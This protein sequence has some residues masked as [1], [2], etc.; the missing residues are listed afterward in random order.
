MVSFLV[1]RMGQIMAARAAELENLRQK[2]EGLTL[3]ADRLNQLNMEQLRLARIE[4]QSK[5]NQIMTDLAKFKDEQIHTFE[6]QLHQQVD[7]VQA[8]LTQHKQEVL[9]SP[10]EIVNRLVDD[11]YHNLTGK[12]LETVQ[13]DQM[14]NL[15]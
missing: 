10:R 9:T 6:T 3:E 7:E 8:K 11:M 14:K 4:M 15:Q 2:A 1:P 13:L 12:K 5:I